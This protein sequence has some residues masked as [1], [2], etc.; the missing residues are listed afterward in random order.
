MKHNISY[1]TLILVWFSRIAVLWQINHVYLRLDGLVKSNIIEKYSGKTGALSF[2]LNLITAKPAAKLGYLLYL[3]ESGFFTF[4]IRTAED[5]LVKS[6]EHTQN[7][8]V[9]L[10]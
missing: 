6:I 10:L 8:D 1:G 2:I 7:E 5:G 3:L 9:T 4:R